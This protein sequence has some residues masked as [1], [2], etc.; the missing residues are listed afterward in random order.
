MCAEVVAIILALHDSDIR[1]IGDESSSAGLAV[2]D[3]H[4][5]GGLMEAMGQEEY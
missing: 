3:K 2:H 1:L 5:V 4:E